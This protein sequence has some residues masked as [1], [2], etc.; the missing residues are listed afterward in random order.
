MTSPRRDLIEVFADAGEVAAQEGLLPEALDE[1]TA[2]LRSTPSVVARLRLVGETEC[3]TPPDMGGLCMACG[4]K[5]A[6]V[7]GHKPGCDPFARVR[8]LAIRATRLGRLY[9][10]AVNPG[11]DQ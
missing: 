5:I 8:R 6:P 3:G 2:R 1:L 9:W 7:A 4:R 10:Q 11:A